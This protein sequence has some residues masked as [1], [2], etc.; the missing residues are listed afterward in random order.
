MKFILKTFVI[1]APS[2]SLSAGDSNNLCYYLLN[3][4]SGIPNSSAQQ[5]NPTKSLS[6]LL[7]SRKMQADFYRLM[8]K[9]IEEKKTWAQFK[10]N[11][12]GESNVQFSDYYKPLYERAYMEKYCGKAKIEGQIQSESSSSSAGRVNSGRKVVFEYSPNL[13]DHNGYKKEIEQG[14]N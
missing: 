4:A 6:L 1:L 11:H 7:T 12:G 2:I 3:H 8:P 5:S 9:A 14:T 10:T 13:N